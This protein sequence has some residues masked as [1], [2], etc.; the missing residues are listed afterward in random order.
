MQVGAPWAPALSPALAGVLS[1]GAAVN[2]AERLDP[3]PLLTPWVCPGGGPFPEGRC[4]LCGRSAHAP[5]VQ[6]RTVLARKTP[7]RSPR[8]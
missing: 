1:A 2:V 8:R 3:G 6:A 5:G 4:L 7:L